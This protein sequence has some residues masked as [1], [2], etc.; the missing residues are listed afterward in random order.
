VVANATV[1]LY[2]S[3]TQAVAPTIHPL[4]ADFWNA[5]PGDPPAGGMWRRAAPPRTVTGLGAGQPAVVRFEWT[6]PAD[7]TARVALLAVCTHPDDDIKTPPLPDTV[8]SPLASPNLIAAERRAA[9]RVVD[10]QPFAPEV[11]VRDGAD[12]SGDA[13]AVAWG[14]RSADI[15]PSETDVPDPDER[16]K[17]LADLRTADTLVGGKKNYL[18]VRVHNRKNVKLTADVEL[19]RAPYDTLHQ[20]GTW[21]PIGAR[22]TVVDVPEKG[23]KFAPK[24]EWDGPPPGDPGPSKVHLVVALITRAGDP[25]PGTGAINDID[26]FWRFFLEGAPAN[27]ASLR[28]LRWHS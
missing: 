8:V 18:Y 11:F 27:N 2:Y 22:V 9:L 21:Q 25:K 4:H 5:F 15:I 16:F 10:V 28:A 23:W 6:P 20:P 24:I 3:N 17:D 26:S 7:S 19:F 13:G 14:G 12:D 1:H